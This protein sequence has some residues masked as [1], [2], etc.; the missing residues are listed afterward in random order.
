V[1]LEPFFC[2]QTSDFPVG[3]PLQIDWFIFWHNSSRLCSLCCR[4]TYTGYVLSNFCLNPEF[5]FGALSATELSP[6]VCRYASEATSS[7]ESWLHNAKNDT[8]IELWKWSFTLPCSCK[9]ASLLSVLTPIGKRTWDQ[10]L[11]VALITVTIEL[12]APLLGSHRP[13]C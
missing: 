12:L 1:H 8:K 6:W 13:A 5:S 3:Q 2:L 11:C 10:P 4:H 7:Y 9:M